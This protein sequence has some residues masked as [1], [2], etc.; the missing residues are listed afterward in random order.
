VAEEEGNFDEMKTMSLDLK[1][2]RPVQKII[3]STL[4]KSW[5]EV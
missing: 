5:C 2:L 1:A 4:G 3:A